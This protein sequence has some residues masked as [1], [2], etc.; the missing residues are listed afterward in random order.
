MVFRDDA[1]KSL[2]TWLRQCRAQATPGSRPGLHETAAT[3]LY[4]E[5]LYE[6][7]PQP[8]WANRGFTA[9]S[10]VKTLLGGGILID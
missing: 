5:D 9:L 4:K 1:S 3:L 2:P 7:F 10:E 6:R 8:T